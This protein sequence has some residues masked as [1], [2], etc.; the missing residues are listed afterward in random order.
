MFWGRP[1]LHGL[2]NSRDAP[3]SSA[4]FSRGDF[5]V[6]LDWLK[7]SMPPHPVEGGCR[8]VKRLRGF[9]DV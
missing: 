3:K 1:Y 2:S 6:V 7:V 5:Y 9:F 8:K 4:G